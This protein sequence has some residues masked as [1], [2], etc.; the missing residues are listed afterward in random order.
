MRIKSTVERYREGE[1]GREE[2]SGKYNLSDPADR[3][4]WTATQ[5]YTDHLERLTLSRAPESWENE[6]GYLRNL[7]FRQAWELEESLRELGAVATG[8][9]QMDAGELYEAA[10]SVAEALFAPE[11]AASYAIPRDFWEAGR[12]DARSGPPPTEAPAELTDTLAP[13]AHML[14]VGLGELVPLAEAAKRAGIG[15]EGMRNR[16]EDRR[17]RSVRVGGRVLIPAADLS[18]E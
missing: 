3:A 2:V 5:L 10:Q 16:A 12:A 13:I 1:I 8:A 15:H 14:L 4:I 7:R 11:G 6:E 9:R 17:V 18:G